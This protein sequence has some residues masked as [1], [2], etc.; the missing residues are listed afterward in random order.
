MNKKC[1]HFW[2]NYRFKIVEYMPNSQN[3]K[4]A[5]EGAHVLSHVYCENCGEVREVVNE[6]NVVRFKPIS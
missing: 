3:P 1:K 5:K 4:F 6:R 2:L